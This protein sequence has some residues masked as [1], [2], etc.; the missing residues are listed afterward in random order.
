VTAGP[1][2]RRTGSLVIKL[3]ATASRC[4][5]AITSLWRADD[6]ATSR[7]FELFYTKLWEDQLGK[8]DALWQAM[9]TATGPAGS[10][11][12]IRSS[13]GNRSRG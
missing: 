10:S 11:V 9:H 8:A 7:F 4:R 5:T 13:A 1:E 6:A 12:A 3:I 2:A